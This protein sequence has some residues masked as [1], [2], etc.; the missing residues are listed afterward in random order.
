VPCSYYS[1]AEQFD[2]QAELSR[3]EL[4]MRYLGH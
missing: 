2:V 1:L 3:D 4:A